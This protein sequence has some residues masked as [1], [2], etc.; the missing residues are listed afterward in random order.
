[1]GNP[2]DTYIRG[3]DYDPRDLL[4][5]GESGGT[6]ALPPRN[7]SNAGNSVIVCTNTNRSLNRDLNDVAILSPTSGVVFPGALVRAN[8]RLAEGKP[9]PVA[10]PRTPVTL[11]IDLPGLGKAGTAVIENPTNSS[12]QAGIDKVLDRWN[13]EAAAEGYVNKARSFL[14]ITKAYSS[15]QLALDLGFSSKW[16]SG[17]VSAKISA[18]SSRESSVA[19]A[20]F[21]QVFY[22]VT[23][24]TP[25]TP[26]SVFADA[27]TVDQVQGLIGEQDP[28]GYVRSVDY[29]RV[30]MIKMETASSETKASLEG[31]LNQVV[32]GGTQVGA[33][34]N[35]KFASI[36][37]N[38][39]F[40][41]VALGGNPGAAATITQ[42]KDLEKLN[43][44][45]VSGSTYGKDNP[46]APIS[47]TV[48]FLKDNQIATLAFTTSYT[49]KECVQ[50]N[51]G[52]IRLLHGGAYVARFFVSWE[53]QD[54]AGD[55]QGKQW[56]SGKKTAGYS[57]Q[58]DLPGDAVNVKILAEAAT[59]LVW[60]PWGQI[61]SCSEKGPTNL[62]YRVGGTTLN[63]SWEKAEPEA[64]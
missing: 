58:I 19:V 6:E 25:A 34:V 41:V 46:G 33:E 12:V 39:T 63:R 61:F 43:E 64:A 55:Y 18:G 50:Y 31:A 60:D 45:I 27:V 13:E 26:A 32:S 11:R 56:E 40:T 35:A 37:E 42:P 30:V 14:S 57:H 62:T 59:G 44:L 3:L 36:I 49:E 48:A 7:R 10:L 8:R 5:V 9:D 2:I 22:T 51:N 52:F 47:Y 17:D 38:S 29:G 15:Q 4:S 1:M 28:P 24:D 16:T 54:E 21:K 20:Y 53:E 23:F